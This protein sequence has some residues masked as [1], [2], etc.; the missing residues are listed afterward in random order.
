MRGWWG[1]YLPDKKSDEMLMD[2]NFSKFVV[3]TSSVG[4]TQNPFSKGIPNIC[5]YFKS[6]TCIVWSVHVFHS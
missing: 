4:T 6:E 5:E 1:C 3:R 2:A